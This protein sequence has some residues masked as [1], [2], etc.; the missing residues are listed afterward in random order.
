MSAVYGAACFSPKNVHKWVKLFREG[1]SSVCDED[2]PGRPTEVRTIAMI[3][4]VDD[5]I[6]SDRRVTVEDISVHSRH[7]SVNFTWFALFSYQKFY[8]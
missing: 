5:I 1:R 8:Y 6:Q 7:S 3:K 2:R 4:S